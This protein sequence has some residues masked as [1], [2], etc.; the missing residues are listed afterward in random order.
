MIVRIICWDSH[1]ISDI[2]ECHYLTPKGNVTAVFRFAL[3]DA[4]S[5]KSSGEFTKIEIIP[6]K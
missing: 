5:R 6:F 1:G 4:L 2:R 3:S